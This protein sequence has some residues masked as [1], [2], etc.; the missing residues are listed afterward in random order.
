MGVRSRSATSGA[1]AL[2][3]W[4][5]AALVLLA[6]PVG[7]LAAVLEPDA[8]GPWVLA[9]VAAAPDWQK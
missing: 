3:Q 2:R 9:G 8:V 5:A 7:V 4:I 6:L 1:P